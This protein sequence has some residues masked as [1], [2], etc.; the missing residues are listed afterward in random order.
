[1]RIKLKD[2]YFEDFIPEKKIQAMVEEIAEKVKNT[3]TEWDNIVIIGVLNGAIPFFKDLV[4]KLPENLTI[5][6]IKTAS[7]F[8]DT[9]SSG[10][11]RLLLDNQMNVEGKDV[12]LVEDIVDSGLTQSFLKEY[13]SAKKVKSFRVC[14]L[15]YKSVNSKTGVAPDFYG[16]DIPDYFIVGYGLDYAQRG[17]NMRGILKLSDNQDD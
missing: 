8:E 10:R 17:R 6:F 16:A 9:K 13:F 7:Y 11:I 2:K 14:S 15:F 3:Y 5:D 4:F 12:L 1:M